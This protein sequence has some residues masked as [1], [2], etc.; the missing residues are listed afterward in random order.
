MI[1]PITPY[2]SEE[3]Y[4]N[5]T[6]EVSVHLSNFPKYNE[7]LIDDKLEEKMDLVRDLISLGR[8]VREEVKI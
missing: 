6:G 5:L 8:N 2:I 3:I 4:Q 7:E 1:A